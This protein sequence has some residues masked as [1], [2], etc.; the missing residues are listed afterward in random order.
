MS[1]AQFRLSA[2]AVHQFVFS[3]AKQE[4]MAALIRRY[5][6]T[7][8]GIGRIIIQMGRN[9]IWRDDEAL[10]ALSRAGD[11]ESRVLSE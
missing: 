3:A 4:E 10:P 6:T 5:G 1:L 11:V 8:T 9:R 7:P 2:P